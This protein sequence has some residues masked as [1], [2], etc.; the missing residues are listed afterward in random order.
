MQKLSTRPAAQ[1][2]ANNASGSPAKMGRE[3]YLALVESGGKTKPRL[4]AKPRKHMLGT[5]IQ[6]QLFAEYAIR[7]VPGSIFCAI[8]NGG[9]RSLRTAI[10]LK[11]EGVKAGVLDT[12]GRGAEQISGIWVEFKSKTEQLT[13]GQK[14]FIAKLDG[15]GERWAV[16]RTLDEGTQLLEAENIL[17]GRAS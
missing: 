17:R 7:G 1:P 4:K 11:R 15:L 9:K 3:E 8:P 5:E 12:W 16:V 13:D 6:K 14:D 10:D 2:Q